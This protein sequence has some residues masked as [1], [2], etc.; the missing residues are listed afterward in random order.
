[1]KTVKVT[2]CLFQLNGSSKLK[3]FLT[4]GL[5]SL[6]IAEKFQVQRTRLNLPKPLICFGLAIIVEP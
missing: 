1:M 3:F 4:F 2:I 6:K 5:L